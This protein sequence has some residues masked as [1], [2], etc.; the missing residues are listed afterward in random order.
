M[1]VAKGV[2]ASGST[3]TLIQGAL[4]IM[5]WTKIKTAVVISACLLLTAGTATT[6]IIH[7]Q[8]QP[9]RAIPKDWAVLN[10]SIDAWS[11]SDDKI[12]AHSTSLESILASSR[13]YRDVTLSVVA[14]TTNRE[15]SLAFRLQDADNGY[16]LIFAPSGT[17]RDGGV[18]H[19]ILEKKT[20]GEEAELGAYR[21]R[22]FSSLGQ[23]AKIEVSAKGPWILVRLNGVIVLR[24]KDT[25]YS[26]G[27][28]GLRIFGDGDYPCDA[29]FS[30]VVY[31]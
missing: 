4:K 5:A 28:I 21:G 1:A 16:L 2:A 29:T 23:S 14:S 19:I 3:L 25:T 11:W 18:G 8:R 9:V 17:P 15:A 7:S 26:A 12:C 10:G 6:I 27:F 22:I 31:Y 24:C 20:S 30:N 13:I